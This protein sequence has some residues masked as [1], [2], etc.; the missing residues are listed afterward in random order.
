LI[1]GYLSKHQSEILGKASDDPTAYCARSPRSW[2]MAARDLDMLVGSSVD[3]KMMSVAG[4]VGVKPASDF[5]AWL[6]HYETVEP[7]VQEIVAGRISDRAK[8]LTVDRALVCAIS[9]T[10]RIRQRANELKAKANLQKGQKPTAE[11]VKEVQK[12]AQNVSKFLLAI[13]NEFKYAAVKST[14]ETSLIAEFS[15]LSVKELAEVYSNLHSAIT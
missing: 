6:D 11:M 9:A 3:R 15:L 10:S 7:I 4:R 5:K 14:L 8:D 12:I 13:P 1:V 2:T